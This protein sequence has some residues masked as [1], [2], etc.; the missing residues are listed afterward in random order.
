[1]ARGLLENEADLSKRQ[2]HL[3]MQVSTIFNSSLDFYSVIQSVI[4]E[5]VSAIDA[6]DGGVLFLY[7]RNSKSLKVAASYGFR[8]KTVNEVMLKSGESMTGMAFAQEKTLHFQTS[9][10]VAHAMDTMSV[11]NAKL[12]K[13]SAEERPLSTI[14]IPI[15]QDNVCTGVIV[16]DRFKQEKPFTEDDIRLVE[17]ISSQAA[18]ALENADLYRNKEISLEKV[19]RFNQTIIHQNEGLS[20]S[21]ETHQ[22]LSD[23]GMEESSFGE[24]CTYLGNAIGKAVMVF[25]P[26][27]DVKASSTEDLQNRKVLKSTII[28]HLH[29]KNGYIN[30]NE[31]DQ[32]IV[33]L[34]GEFL[35]FPLGRLTFPLGYLAVITDKRSL[36]RFE[37]SAVYHACTVAGLQLMKKESEH[38]EQQRLTSELLINVLSEQEDDSDLSYVSNRLD[39]SMDGYFTAAVLDVPQE[40]SKEQEEWLRRCI[41]SA[42]SHLLTN[43][44]DIQVL[45]TEWGRQVVLIFHQEY[46]KGIESSIITVNRFMNDFNQLIEDI[47]EEKV[48]RIG[49]GKPVK[50]LLALHQSFQEAKKTIKFL[51]RFAFAGS[52]SWYEELGA[53]RLL[54]NNKEDELA[55]YAFEYLSP[56]L[57]YEKRRKGELFQ[58]LFVYLST[59]QDLK[60]ASE[61]LHVHVNTMNYRIQRIQEIM[62][63]EFNNPT[64]LLNIQVACNIYRY[65]YE[66]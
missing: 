33:G 13:Q 20:K 31:K 30:S 64:D 60:D 52:T 37:H 3:L 38:K 22:A 10:E 28:N 51:K 21:V 7:D 4:E 53:L 45:V 17:A 12:Y 41:H 47:S 50:G 26:F 56:L 48:C 34:E 2:L 35:I 18:I 61:Q 1:M 65:L 44:S 16:L 39:T 15:I 57:A 55:N 58:T 9:K 24:I 11:Q 36:T 62:N 49:I 27:G 8:K 63:I 40:Y 46:K 42:I 66:A 14:C 54:L 25:D 19:Q 23:I 5:A 32:A 43:N 59:G 6:A 29:S